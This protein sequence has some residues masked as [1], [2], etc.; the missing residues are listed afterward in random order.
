MGVTMA[1]SVMALRMYYMEA[2]V[3]AVLGRITYFREEYITAI[4]QH[5]VSWLDY[6]SSK[7]EMERV[8]AERDLLLSLLDWWSENPATTFDEKELLTSAVVS[9]RSAG[10]QA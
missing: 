4:E 9:L 3:S 8:Q 10:R 7:G 6:R 1:P 5:R 2:Y